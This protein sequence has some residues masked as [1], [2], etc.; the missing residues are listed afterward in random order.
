MLHAILISRGTNQT[1]QD[2]AAE[3]VGN[4][5]TDNQPY[6]RVIKPLPDK[7]TVG[8]DQIR[9]L[10]YFLNRRP[11]QGQSN[12]A[13]IATAEPMTLQAQN[14]L[15]K[16]LEEPPVGAR[17]ILLTPHE[18]RLLP[19]I[20]SRCQLIK[21]DSQFDFDPGSKIT[22]TL[23]AEFNQVLKEGRGVALDYTEKL[24]PK[25]KERE[26]TRQL[27]TTWEV[28]LRQQLIDQLTTNQPTE[29]GA[30]PS[31]KLPSTAKLTTSLRR[32]EMT[33]R[34]VAKTNLNPH[35]AVTALLLEIA[36]VVNRRPSRPS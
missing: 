17:I 27:L 8:I 36:G 29:S 14:A 23:T 33:R 9:S 31:P 22:Q 32:I 11:P 1:R 15:L 16:T 21:L 28:T 34:L 12:Q 18:N 2:R 4:P 10:E 5:L 19:T 3:L 30:G 13:I 6:Q 26:F 24:K 25:L 20:I 7:K 35:L